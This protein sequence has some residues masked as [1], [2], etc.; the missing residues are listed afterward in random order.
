LGSHTVLTGKR[1]LLTF[2]A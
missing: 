2:A 1:R